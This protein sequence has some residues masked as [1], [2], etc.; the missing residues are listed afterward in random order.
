MTLAQNE[1]QTKR[2]MDLWP[3]F[4]WMF[5]FMMSNGVGMTVMPVL[6]VINK[7]PNSLLGTIGSIYFAGMF[8]GYFI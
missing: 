6:A 2:L 1:T 7:M 5:F 3:V 8:L 4:V